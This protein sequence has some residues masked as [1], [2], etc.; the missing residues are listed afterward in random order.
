MNANIDC[1]NNI[2]KVSFY[3]YC[4]NYKDGLHKIT[5]EIGRVQTIYL[6]NT[7]LK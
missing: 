6:Y 7:K 1:D 4:S 5:F 2:S 3:C